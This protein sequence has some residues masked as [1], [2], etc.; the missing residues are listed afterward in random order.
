MPTSLID[1]IENIDSI[2][3][4]AEGSVLNSMIQVYDKAL[5]IIESY[6][7]D[8][9]SSFEIFQE[10]FLSKKSKE[11]TIST[12]QQKE[13]VGKKILLFLPRLI[14][15]ASNLYKNILNKKGLKKLKKKLKKKGYKLDDFSPE[16]LKMLNSI[17]A[18]ADK[19]NGKLLK[20]MITLRVLEKNASKIVSLGFSSVLIGGT[21]YAIKN[22]QLE[23][24]ASAVGEVF[25]FDKIGEKITNKI[26]DASDEAVQNIKNAVDDGVQKIQENVEK[27]AAKIAELVEKFVNNIMS[28]YTNI[29]KVV[30]SKVMKYTTIKDSNI[31]LKY[32]R[33]KD[34][35][36]ISFDLSKWFD[37]YTVANGCLTE[38]SEYLKTRNVRDKEA[39]EKIATAK[40]NI[41][42]ASSDQE[43][44]KAQKEYV[45]V[46]DKIFNKYE[47]IFEDVYKSP[48]NNQ[49]T[50]YSPADS[51]LDQLENSKNGK[52]LEALLT[53]NIKHAQTL[54][55]QFSSNEH[56]NI[57]RVVS[58]I[59]HIMQTSINV[60]NTIKTIQDF[61]N[62]TYNLSS[63]FE[64]ITDESNDN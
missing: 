27:A 14:K 26:H 12:E 54:C 8:D 59:N 46:F 20:R 3:I 30:S 16:E 9:L 22:G 33:D 11:S 63:N 64:K 47:S 7:G 1:R 24:V 44:N 35:L 37:W 5:S 23:K 6:E 58:F 40:N 13:S 41:K 57:Q 43:K 61:L 21:Y 32:D 39:H 4:E 25:H 45:D 17:D 48:L 50:E 60:L 15:H 18:I 31:C 49:I 34:S 51:F 2:L 10:G 29:Q 62:E 36:K 38:C 52:S 42:N 56:S 28:L 53:A 55:D 19:S